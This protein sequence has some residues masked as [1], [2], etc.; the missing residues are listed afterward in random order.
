MLKTFIER[1]VLS[2]VISIILV[3]LGGLGVLT[4][5]IE[6]Y[7]DIAPPTVQVNATYPGASAETILESVIIPI[8]EQINGVEGMTYITSTATNAGTANVTVYFDQNTDPDIAAVN[9]QNRVSRANALLPQE[10]VQTGVITQKQQTSSLMFISFFS[11]NEDYDATYVQN[12]LKINVIPE[13]QR[14]NGVGDVNV[15]SSQDY[16]MRIWLK[17]DKLSAYNLIPSDVSAALREQSLEAAAGSLGENNGEAFSYVIKY[18]GRFKT[19]KQYG[20]IIIKALGNGQYLRLKDVADIELS[21]QSFASSSITNGYPSVNMAIYQTKGSNAQEIIETIHEKLEN[22]KP[23]FP[24]GIDLFIP[25]DTNDFLTASIDKVVH[26]LIEAFILVFLVVFIFLQDVRSTLIPA[27]AVP[28]AII[29][30]FFFLNVFGYSINLLTLF[31]LVLAIGIVVDDAIVVVEAV[32][33]KIEEGNEKSAKSATINAMTEISGAIISIT[34]VMAAV[35]IPVTFIQGP[36]GVFYEQFGVTLIVA[37]MISAV[38]ALTLSPA[39]CALFLKVHT[40]EEKKNTT[41][42]QRFYDGFNKG[43]SATTERY[44]RSLGFLYKHKWITGVALLASIAGIIWVSSTTPTGFVPN[45]DRGIIFANVEL[46]AGSSIDRTGE[47]NRLLYEKTKDLPGVEGVS[48]ISG[49]SLLG[50]QGS[51]YGLGFI[52][53]KDWEE[54]GEDSLSVDALTKKLFGIATTI[55]EANIIF[56]APPSIPGFGIS[57]GFEVNLLDRSG[58]A[59]TELDEANRDF[60]MALMKHPEI[61]YAQSSFNTK[62]PQYEMEINVPVA[63]EKGVPISSIF[64]TLQGYIGGI[65]AADFARFGKQYRVYLQTLPESR[66][67]KQSLNELYVRTGEGEMAPITQFV[68]LKRVYGPQSVTRFNLFNSSKITGASNP[69]YSTGDAIAVVEAEAANLPSNYDI[70][71]S[72]L[73]REEVN[74]GSQTIL[75]F[76]LSIVFVYFL[77]SAQYESYLL[78]FSVILSLPLGV[79]GAYFTTK[80]VGLENNIFFQIALIMLIG[81]LAKNAILI[82]EFALQ[83]RRRGES[84]ADAAIHGAKARLRPILMTSFAFILGLMPLALAG[85]VGAAGNRSIG[86]G[87]AGGMLIGTILGVFAIPILFVVFQWLQEKIS[88]APEAIVES[89]DNLN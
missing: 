42:L 16:A 5:P 50:G 4:L 25:Y 82:V 72:G 46:P 85:G 1:P 18:S 32:H 28:V 43:F 57:S 53:L 45:E 48:V 22:L 38:N 63:K 20:D 66:D 3:I 34:L 83:R 84:L 12:Y 74:A 65:Y 81:L 39:L 73:T 52:K 47:V 35:F 33:A 55:P 6:Q 44:G 89:E 75:I 56:F 68:K 79:F 9:V 88:G 78:P 60:M 19:E 37:I 70:A 29:G 58:G 87:A 11:S 69:G 13:L 10:V 24:K 76:I 40:E 61:Q 41:Y 77:L 2:T 62:Y 80:M 51:N 7:P 23:D 15:F 14:V 26:T 31:A 8:E 71:Y 67:N 36:T 30:T 17:P 27:I 21:A 49:F 86:T 64:S 59:F 54:R